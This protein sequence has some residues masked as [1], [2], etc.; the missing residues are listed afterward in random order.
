MLDELFKGLGY[1]PVSAYLAG[2][3]G[4]Q[5]M[6]WAE[7]AWNAAK[8]H[9]DEDDEHVV[10]FGHAVCLPAMAMV[11]CAEKPDLVEKLAAINMGEADGFTIVFNADGEPVSVIPFDV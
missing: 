5:V 1:A 11:I 8:V 2:K 7:T 9:I 3:D 4:D 6:V 10:I